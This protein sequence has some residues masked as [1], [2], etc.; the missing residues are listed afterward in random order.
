MIETEKVMKEPRPE[1]ATI[2]LFRVTF[3]LCIIEG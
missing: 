2:S 1:E 3:M